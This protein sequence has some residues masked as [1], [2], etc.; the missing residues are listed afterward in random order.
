MLNPLYNYIIQIAINVK[1]LF[2]GYK[3]GF[4]KSKF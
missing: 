4:I 1:I 2:S 3:Y